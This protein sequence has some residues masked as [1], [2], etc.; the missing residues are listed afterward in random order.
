VYGTST[1][2][3]MSVNSVLAERVP[4]VRSE[5]NIFLGDYF[6]WEFDI[7]ETSADYFRVA[8]LSQRSRRR[9]IRSASTVPRPPIYCQWFRDRRM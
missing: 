1:P 2:L 5:Y 9:L 3:G 8:S 7:F 6:P 4:P